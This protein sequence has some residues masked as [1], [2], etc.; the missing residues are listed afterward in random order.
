MAGERVLDTVQVHR[1]IGLL[2]PWP[3]APLTPI[4]AG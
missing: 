2:A 1:R 3:S 4:I